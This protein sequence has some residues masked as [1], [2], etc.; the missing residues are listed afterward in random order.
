MR[1]AVLL[2]SVQRIL[3]EDVTVRDAAYAWSR[4]RWV[5]P[6]GAA[7]F[8][9]IV[10]LAPV[11]DIEDWPTRIVLGLAGVGVAVMAT[12]DYRVVAETDRGIR[13]LKASRIRQVAIADGEGVPQGA[14]MEPIGGTIIAAD[15]QVGSHRY[16]VPRSSEQAMERMAAG[17]RA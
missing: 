17:H 10:F 9:A 1:R 13:V 16:T 5:A 8:A 7:V 12:T 11:A 2:R 3:G 6:F 14:V 4:H 15:W